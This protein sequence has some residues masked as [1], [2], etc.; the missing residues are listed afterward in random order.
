MLD[1]IF[2]SELKVK[3]IGFLLSQNPV[4]GFSHNDI[5]KALSLKGTVWRRELN[6]LVDVGLIKTEILNNSEKNVEEESS[7]EDKKQKKVKKDKPSSVKKN[8]I[9]KLIYKI[10]ENFFVYSEIKSLFSKSRILLARKVFKDIEEQCHPKLVILTGK[11]VGR[12]DDMV[13][14]LIVGC[15]AKRTFLKLLEELQLIMGEEINYSLM[16]EEEF[17]YR[18]YVMDIFLY[19][20]I[21]SD[22]MIISGDIADMSFFKKEDDDR[23]E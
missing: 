4:Q 17:K 19:N 2:G 7:Q 3:I 12:P 14:L 5:A 15:S 18:R 21:E 13:D 22:N 8:K 16:T 23:Q 20:I 6:D 9:E 11:F 1:R 10:D